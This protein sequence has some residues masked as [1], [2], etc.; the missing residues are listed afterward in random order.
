MPHL[1]VAV[2]E[3]SSSLIKLSTIPAIM[4]AN[5]FTVSRFF[6][7]SQQNCHFLDL[8]TSSKSCGEPQR[9]F[10]TLSISFWKHTFIVTLLK[11]L[12]ISVSGNLEQWSCHLKCFDK[13]WLMTLGKYEDGKLITK[14]ID[15]QQVVL[16]NPVCQPNWKF[17]VLSCLQ[18]K[19]AN[20]MKK[21]FIVWIIFWVN[22]PTN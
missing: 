9:G 14:A 4:C 16:S 13:I 10:D 6:N 18:S 19:Q 8:P 3:N 21:L 2:K 5:L 22:K 1:P 17:A 12:N 7:I 11:L 15:L 20:S